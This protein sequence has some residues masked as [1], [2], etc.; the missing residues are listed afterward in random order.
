V[1]L[2]VV[3]IVPLPLAAGTARTVQ[4]VSESSVKLTLPVGAAAPVAEKVAV[5][6][7][8]GM[9]TPAVPVL[10]DA[11]PTLICSVVAPQVVVKPLLLLS[12]A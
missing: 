11:L 8:L 10:G 4:A 2:P 6:L 7:R 1:V 5:S 12:P 3:L 9:F